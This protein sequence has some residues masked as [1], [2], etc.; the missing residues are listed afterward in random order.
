MDTETSTKSVT[1]TNSEIGFHFGH[2]HQTPQAYTPFSP[3]L[4][5]LIH[6]APGRHA[7]TRPESLQQQ[8]MAQITRRLINF[9]GCLENFAG[10]RPTWS[11]RAAAGATASAAQAPLPARSINHGP[12]HSSTNEAQAERAKTTVQRESR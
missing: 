8:V 6:P 3:T 7:T 1:E 10:R 12:L 11:P 5:T 2:V 9:R 4:S